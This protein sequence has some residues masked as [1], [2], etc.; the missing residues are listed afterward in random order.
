MNKNFIARKRFGQH[1]LNPGQHLERLIQAVSPNKADRFIEIGPGQGVLTEL[2]LPKVGLLVAVEIDRDL[3]A[4]LTHTL[5]SPHFELIN[6]DVLRF[7]PATLAHPAPFRVLGNLPY[8]IS[9]PLLLQL[10]DWV[11]YMA[12]AHFMVQKEVADRLCATPGTK[13]FGRLTVM[14]HDD[15]EI[16]WLFDVPPSAFSP[17]P[18]VM[19]SIIR[20]TPVKQEPRSDAY[21]ASF[22]Q[23]VKAA[24]SQRRKQLGNVLAKLCTP[25]DLAAVGIDRTARAEDISLATYR[26]LTQFLIDHKKI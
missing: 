19:S 9:T 22:E 12:D 26:S 18:K 8:N 13:D 1:F 4:Y 14:L 23:V 6:Q 20:L 16:E 3:A 15:F 10:K 2:V 7:S 17:P 24:F 25:E 11:P 5:K 21:R